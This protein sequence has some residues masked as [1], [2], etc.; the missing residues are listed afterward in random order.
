MS[1]IA[2]YL[3]AKLV[4]PQRE[5]NKALRDLN[6][7]QNA[8]RMDAIINEA[9]NRRDREWLLWLEQAIANND[10]SNPPGSQE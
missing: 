4:K 7:T 9:V 10:F 6:L 3:E 8:E 1:G 2:D 5:K